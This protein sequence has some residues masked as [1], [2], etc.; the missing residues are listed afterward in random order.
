MRSFRAKC[1]NLASRSLGNYGYSLLASAAVGVL[2]L[3]LG[4]S[5]DSPELLLAIPL[6]Q[7]VTSVIIEQAT[8]RSS[9]HRGSREPGPALAHSQHFS[10]RG[11]CV[12]RLAPYGLMLSLA[13]TP[14]AA[15]ARTAQWPQWNAPQLARTW[16]TRAA[17][18]SGSIPGQ[19]AGGLLGGAVGFVGGAFIGAAIGGGNTICGDDSCGLEEAAYG[20]VIGEATLLPLGVHLANHRRGNYGLSLLASAAVAGA[21]LLAVD[22]ANDGWPLIAIP[23]GQLISSILIERATSPR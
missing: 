11:L 10:N 17:P 19:V 6:G 7:L 14:L 12:K 15:Q 23:V 2:S 1:F 21:G 5:S 9:Q 4:S 8:S 13:T 22:A 3:T 18:R 20:A 16:E